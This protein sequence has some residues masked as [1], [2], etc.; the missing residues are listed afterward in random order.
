M[1]IRD[2]LKCISLSK[3]KDDKTINMDSLFYDLTITKKEH[4]NSWIKRVGDGWC[5]SYL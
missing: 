1:C 3:I 2:S 5:S 4:I